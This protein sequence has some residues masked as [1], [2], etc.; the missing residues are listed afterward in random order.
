MSR[1]KESKYG[2]VTGAG[3]LYSAAK[4]R[5]LGKDLDN[6]K[7][8][9]QNGL[10]A[11]FNAIMSVAELQVATMSGLANLSLQ[12]DQLQESVWGINEHFRNIE[13]REEI[14][15]DLKLFLINLEEEVENINE[16][17]ENYPE[18][19]LLLSEELVLLLENEGVE[20][21]HFKRMPS[22]A[23]IKW[24]KSV[25]DSVTKTYSRLKEVVLG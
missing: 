20:I 3:A 22:T 16:I 15:G 8:S 21:E 11:N 25:L 23:D 19:A 14:L 10:N 9:I 7:S 18:Y 1:P 6:F 4:V 24:A 2:L 13:M 17:S 5:K 12:I